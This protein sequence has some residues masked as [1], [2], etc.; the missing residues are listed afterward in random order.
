MNTNF[1]RSSTFVSYRGK[2]LKTLLSNGGLPNLFFIDFN[3]T[4]NYENPESLIAHGLNTCNKMVLLLSE[5]YFESNWCIAEYKCCALL[6]RLLKIELRAYC[7]SDKDMILRLIDMNNL[8][9]VQ[10]TE[11]M[12]GAIME[13]ILNS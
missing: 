12:E 5:E 9:S 4:A 8:T 1:P 2:Q 13:N 11:I 10:L 6:H 3:V 7:W